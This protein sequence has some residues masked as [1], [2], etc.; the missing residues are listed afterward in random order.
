V[1]TG[2][3]WLRLWPPNSPILVLVSWPEPMQVEH[4]RTVVFKGHNLTCNLRL[5]CKFL[6]GIKTW[7]NFGVPLIKRKKVF[8]TMTLGSCTIKHFWLVIYGKWVPPS[9]TAL[10]IMTFSVKPFSIMALSIMP[11]SIK[12]LYATLSINDNHLYMLCH[13]AECHYVLSLVFCLFFFLTPLCWV[14]QISP[15]CWA[16]LCSI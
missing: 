13:Y 4:L 1:E 2:S 8:L 7:A 12:S 6:L 11:F 16:S 15:L 14:S 5:C 3:K 10:S 9:I